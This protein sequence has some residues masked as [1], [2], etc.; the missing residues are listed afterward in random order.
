[1]NKDNSR[2]F[3]R[4]SAGRT[5]LVLDFLAA[6]EPADKTDEQGVS[7]IKWCAFHGDVSALRIL[8]D[9][10]EKLL[11]L[12]ADF[13]LNAAAFHGH[14]ELCQFLLNNG[15]DANSK[16]S[17]TGETPLHAALCKANRPIYDHVV[18]VLLAHGA[19][20]NTK[21][22]AGV[23]TGA[24]MRDC[25]TRG[26]TPLHRA[27]AYG[28]ERAIRMLLEAGADKT[29]KDANND[30]PLSWASWHLRPASVLR[31]LCYGRFSIHPDNESDYDH[32]S[33]WNALDPG[34]SG[35]PESE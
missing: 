5:D 15:A 8:L 18:Q 9:K 28:T 32:G 6:G 33:G 31:L 23:E 14:W 20:P 2:L 21:T 17:D 4:I 10:G 3:Q 35:W 12:G 11:S 7:L 19:D 13:G 26:E 16:L 25:R 29:I 34:R 22:L 30:S 1:M 24:F 27:A